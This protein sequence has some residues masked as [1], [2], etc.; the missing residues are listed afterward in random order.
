M[1][2]THRGSIRRLVKFALSA[3]GEDVA[4]LRLEDLAVCAAWR[5]S[6]AGP[7]PEGISPQAVAELVERWRREVRPVPIRTEGRRQQP[8]LRVVV[9][10][11]LRGNA[12]ALDR[13]ELDVALAAWD[14][15]EAT[16]ALV[17][18]HRLAEI[19]KGQL[20]VL[21]ALRE[22]YPPDPE[23]SRLEEKLVILTTED[24]LAAPAR[25]VKSFGGLTV[26]AKGPLTS[27]KGELRILGDLPESAMLVVDNGSATI[28]GYMLGRIVATGACE[29]RETI[30]GIAVSRLGDIRARAI[31]PKAYAV[32]RQGE[33]HLGMAEAPSLVFAGGAIQVRD[34]TQGGVY[35]APR[36]TIGGEA[37]GG[38]YVASDRLEAQRFRHTDTRALHIVLRPWISAE[39]FEELVAPEAT[40]PLARL[41][42]L[43]RRRANIT[44]LIALAE[45]EREHFATIALM[46]LLGGEAIKR[47]VEELNVIRRRLGFLDRVIEGIDALRA[48]AE[49]RLKTS[50]PVPSGDT[51]AEED[52]FGD[53]ARELDEY[54]ADEASNADLRTERTELLSMSRRITR[55]TIQTAVLERL[56]QKKAQ[57]ESEKK[58]LRAAAEAKDVALRKTIGGLDALGLDDPEQP[59]VKTLAQ[60][61]LRARQSAPNDPMAER[62]N[63]QFLRILLRTIEGRGQR[64]RQY[65]AALREVN[66]A[67]RAARDALRQNHGIMTPDPD[68]APDHTPT[69]LGRFSPGIR[70]ALDRASI[71]HTGPNPPGVW[72]TDDS[73]EQRAFIR[74][75][76][77]IRERKSEH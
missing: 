2:D 23:L 25:P 48:A 19:I 47:N 14:L 42:R 52:A 30:S 1:A 41:A 58:D 75:G 72:V 49:E 29:I 3:R 69:A 66:E 36:I 22:S 62:L 76:D 45:S 61:V 35:A 11:L 28:D 56:N 17:P 59:K 44:E 43:R 63:A 55:E 46:Y 60:L 12:D 18:Q 65:G 64:I 8:F 20:P 73:P 57:W 38:E 67:I 21:K 34:Q 33:V 13:G 10:R 15:L 74:N 37:N 24:L 39:D 77:V 32:A 26:N 6:L 50:N 5:Q 9:D 16:G 4:R 53:V 7:A 40:V 51:E 71:K 54:D 70:L 31:I 68:A 27:V